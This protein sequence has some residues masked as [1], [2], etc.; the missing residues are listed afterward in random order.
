MR[1]HLGPVIVVGYSGH[2]ESI[3]KNRV[4][5]RLTI[6]SDGCATDEVKAAVRR[7]RESDAEFWYVAR[8]RAQLRDVGRMTLSAVAEAGKML[9]TWDPSG[10]DE[11]FP[12]TSLRDVI[13]D[14]LSSSSTL[15]TFDGI[16][17][18]A[19]AYKVE[20][21]L[22]EPDP[23]VASRRVPGRKATRGGLRAV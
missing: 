3:I 2:A 20:P 11:D 7:E 1:D 10:T 9:L 17:N 4:A 5:R 23:S 8:P 14:I 6:L 22:D 18:V 21:V 15:F 19:P 16:E 13:K 12:K